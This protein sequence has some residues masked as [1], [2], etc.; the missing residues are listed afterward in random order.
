MRRAEISPLKKHIQESPKLQELRAKRVSLRRRLVILFSI[1][2]ATIISAFVFFARYPRLQIETIVVSG[3]QIISTDEITKTVDGFLDGNYA[4]VIPHRNTFFYPKK[5]IIA[6]L[7]KEFPRLKTI[8]VYRTSK[9]TLAVSVTEL[10]GYALWCGADAST[11]DMTAPCWF[12]DDTGKIISI[13]P[14]YSGNVYPRFFGGSLSDSNPLGKTFVS[15]SEFQSLLM[16][17]SRIRSLGFQVKAITI[18][19]GPEYSFVL[20]LGNKKT[21]I[22]RFLSSANYQTLA[23]NLTL[24]LSKKELAD[25]V[26]KNRLNLQYFDLRFTNKLYYKFSEHP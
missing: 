13:A 2:F 18:P 23:D 9:M 24:A 6:S 7:A 20:D 4:Y 26:K 22:V 25:A 8:S 17:E 15:Q 12:T 16:F 10:R 1:L 21:A 14:Y 11:I 3:N 5:K 19:P